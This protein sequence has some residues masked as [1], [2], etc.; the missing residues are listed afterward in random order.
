MA[1]DFLN[2]E[3]HEDNDE[4]FKPF[5]PTKRKKTSF[6]AAL[7]KAAANW[8]GKPTETKKAVADDTKTVTFAEL[9][10]GYWLITSTLGTFAMTE[11]TPDKEDVTINEKNPENTITKEVK[12][13][14]T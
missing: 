13:D 7:A 1:K 12:E 5:S 14:S 11:T 10:N 8:T 2:Q 3:F 4:I 6:P 9:P